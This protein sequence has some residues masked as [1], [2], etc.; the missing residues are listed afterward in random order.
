MYTLGQAEQAT[1]KRKSTIANAIKKGR[2]SAKKNDAG[3]WQI[4]PAELHRVYPPVSS[5]GTRNEKSNDIAP[6]ET[7]YELIELRVKVKVLE[8]Q[9]T[10]EREQCDH[11]QGQAERVS[12]LLTDQREKSQLGRMAKAWA[13]LTGKA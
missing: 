12:Q 6:H 9:L 13:A 1:G 3:E 7:P 4:D 11:W 2:I 5:D 10:R 8:E